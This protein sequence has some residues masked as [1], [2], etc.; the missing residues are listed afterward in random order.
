[1]A[2]IPFSGNPLDRASNLRQDDAWVSEQLAAPSSRF[3]LVSRLEVLTHSSDAVALAW[4]DGTSCRGLE[5][6]A[7]P[8]LLGLRDGIAHFALDVSDA[9]DVL[10]ALA[11]EGAAF[12]EARGL[13]TTLPAEDAGIVAQA[14]ALVDWHN[15]HRFCGACGSPTVPKKG[16]AQR[17]C[18][19]CG[20]QHFPR[21]DPVVIMV[22]W[23]EDRCLLGRRRGRG[24]GAFSCIAG[25]IDQGETIEEAVRREVEEE[26]GLQVDKVVYQASQPWPFPS[27]LM[28]GCFAHATSFDAH[29][30]EV[31]I[32]E[33]RWFTRDDV[34]AAVAAT[35]PELTIPGPVAIAHHLIRAWS[36]QKASDPRPFGEG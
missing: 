12:A 27:T 36:E 25:Y 15:R 10:P 19:S 31:E 21:T 26:V 33:A 2:S 24:A 29:V 34:C 7:T 8:V 14:R 13:A 32:E 5:C 3:L 20:A 28:I 30:D 11:I 4:I 23:R 6:T 16:G 18:E 35:N 9:A 1:L 22:V 17:Q